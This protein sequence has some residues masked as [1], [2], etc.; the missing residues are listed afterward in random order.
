MNRNFDM[1]KKN[2]KLG[3]RLLMD[4]LYHTA[5]KSRLKSKA[6]LLAV[7]VACGWVCYVL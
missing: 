3:L 5:S 7:C 6:S 2:S 1:L 4:T